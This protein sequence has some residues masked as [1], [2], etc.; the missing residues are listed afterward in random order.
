MQ[1]NNL[2]YNSANCNKFVFAWKIREDILLIS[3]KHTQIKLR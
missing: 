3:L 1:Y 2:C